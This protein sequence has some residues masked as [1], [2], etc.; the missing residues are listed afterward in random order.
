[1]EEMAIWVNVA[2][3]RMYMELVGFFD[4][5]EMK[6]VYDTFADEV[7]Q[8][9]A[10]FDVITDV[11]QFKPTTAEGAETMGRT[12]QLAKKSGLNR[13]IRVVGAEVGSVQVARKE[14]ESGIQANEAAS[15]AEAESIL[16]A[17]N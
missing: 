3:N 9:K 8:L 2:K 13:V 4:D 15:M 16:D 10:G 6:Q 14:R 5:E 12:Q 7:K 11:S 1:M 17:A